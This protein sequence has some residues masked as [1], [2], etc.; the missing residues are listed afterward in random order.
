VLHPADN[1]TIL[2]TDIVVIDLYRHLMR[3]HMMIPRENR[4]YSPGERDLDVWLWLMGLSVRELWVSFKLSSALSAQYA[5][6]AQLRNFK[7]PGD[8]Q[9][10]L[11][12]TILPSHVKG[13][14]VSQS[15]TEDG[16]HMLC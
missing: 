13:H 3:S 9:P 6:S 8:E 15:N 16:L 14:G 11:F 2:Q 5:I 1:Y 7:E 4:E 12:F 10:L